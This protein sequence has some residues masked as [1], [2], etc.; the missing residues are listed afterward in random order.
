MEFGSILLLSSIVGIA[1]L[2]TAALIGAFTGID[3]LGAILSFFGTFM[4]VLTRTISWAPRWV[5][6][7]LFLI[8]GVGLLGTISNWAV[9]SDVVCSDGVVYQADSFLSATMAKMLPGDQETAVEDTDAASTASDSSAPVVES[10]SA[11]S[12]ISLLLYDPATTYPAFGK[13]GTFIQAGNNVSTVPDLPMSMQSKLLIALPPYTVVDN[14]NFSEDR[15]AFDS[16]LSVFKFSEKATLRV[17]R[18]T[19]LS[20]YISGRTVGRC[21]LDDVST[22]AGMIDNFGTTATWLMDDVSIIT[23]RFSTGELN[24]RRFV[25]LNVEY[26]DLESDGG[27]NK[28][29][30]TG[31]PGEVLLRTSPSY[32]TSTGSVIQIVSQEG[33]VSAKY[34]SVQ[35]L[36]VDPDSL[37]QEGELTRRSSF[38]SKSGDSFSKW[39][40]SSDDSITYSCGDGDQVNVLVWGLDVFNFQT[41]ILLIAIG[42]IF[43]LL[44]KLNL[45]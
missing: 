11:I 35:E 45:I 15:F 26:T 12:D 32:Q 30:Q 27:L 18:E 38:I 23:Y 40:G 1:G 25:N 24:D 21:Y 29:P 14:Y 43:V 4:N 41:L 3:I 17:M 33:W 8:V 13:W 42:V 44:G 28:C 36:G 2:A 10:P 34:F 9:A 39:V 22:L 20:S 5:Q 7:G 37:L 6:V 19:S 31:L 16:N